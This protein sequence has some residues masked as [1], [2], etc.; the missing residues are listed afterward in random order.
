MLSYTGHPLVDVG[1]A[2][3]TSL[4]GKRSPQQ[5]TAEDLWK[6]GKLL[7]RVYFDEQWRG[8]MFSIFPNSA[9]TQPKISEAKKRAYIETF[10]YGFQ[11]SHESD[12]RCTFCRKPALARSYRQHIPLLTGKGAINFFPRGRSGL[13]ACGA[14]LLAIQ[15]FLLGSVKCAGRALLVHSHEN[16]LT[17]EFAQRSLRE[18]R[19][20]ISLNSPPPN[21]NHPRTYLVTRLLEI[22][23]DRHSMNERERPYSLTAYHLTNYGTNPDIALFHFPFQLISFLRQARCGPHARVWMQIEDRAWELTTRKNAQPEPDHRRESEPAVAASARERLGQAR[24]Y[25][26]EDLLDLPQNG[27]QFIRTYLLRRTH[28]S[29]FEGDPRRFYDFQ[30]ELHLISW[31]ITT[32]F[33]KE[34]MNLDPHRI[35]TIKRV[36]DR[37]ANH[38]SAENNRRL[39]RRLS[40]SRGASQLRREL[41]TEDRRLAQRGMEPL[42]TMDDFIELF[43][44]GEDG[45]RPDWELA[46]DLVLIRVIEQLHQRDWFSANPDEIDEEEAAH[47][48]EA[49]A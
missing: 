14:C 22:E 34:V 41:V 9:Y 31:K 25:L 8:V 13:P 20:F 27:A 49:A 40:L 36:A 29:S 47:E 5:L 4:V 38:I 16:E 39:F 33:L 32:I 35:E 11:A 1:I 15:A 28:R 48:V 21:L 6:T 37:I 44:L 12:E 26:Y 43:E 2:T 10:I 45:R 7:E 18:N 42:F 24:N 23:K 3:I 46:T 19:R 30:R 17:F